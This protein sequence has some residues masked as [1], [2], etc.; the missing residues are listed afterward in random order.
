MHVQETITKIRRRYWLLRHLQRHGLDQMELLK[1]YMTIIRSTIEYA[2]VVYGPMLTKEQSDKIEHLQS[3]CLKII[4]GFY[5]SY[6][7]LLEHTGLERLEQRRA[8]AIEKFAMKAEQGSYKK[9][10]PRRPDN[11][12]TRRP[13][14]FLES[15]ARCDRL[16]NTPIFHMRRVLNALYQ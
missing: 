10:F 9:W 4:F 1:V 12:R 13:K 6:A 16:K 3:Q 8:R 15:Y 5:H 11:G 7:S 2:S 14:K